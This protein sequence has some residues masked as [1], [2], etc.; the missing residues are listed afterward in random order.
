MSDPLAV[1]AGAAVGAA[2]ATVVAILQSRWQLS[3]DAET[4][5]QLRLDNE[6]SRLRELL[7]P[8]VGVVARIEDAL[9]AHD[10][11]DPA[12][13]LKVARE[14]Y[15][16][17]VGRLMLE[18]SHTQTRTAFVRVV[19]SLQTWVDLT[20]ELNALAAGD[21]KRLVIAEK[22]KACRASLSGD[23]EGFL[24]V[25]RNRVLRVVDLYAKPEEAPPRSG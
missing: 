23:L 7:A 5:R 17:V 6:L 16:S 25:A 21:Q 1:L 15:G 8:L 4:A 18:A 10:H 20:S 19:E 9:T 24:G 2:A 12:S 14:A 3:R 22:A 13:L 11:A